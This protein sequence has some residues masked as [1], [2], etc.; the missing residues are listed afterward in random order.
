MTHSV[1]SVT[2]PNVQCACAQDM[3]T[4]LPVNPL[5]STVISIERQ[6]F[7]VFDER[8]RFFIALV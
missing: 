8:L 5:G 3:S 6:V 2:R 4:N 1:V 7:D